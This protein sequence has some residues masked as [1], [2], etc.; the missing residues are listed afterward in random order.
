M[1]VWD[2]KQ[3]KVMIDQS[4]KIYARYLEERIKEIEKGTKK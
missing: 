4:E 3:T 2:I 1:S